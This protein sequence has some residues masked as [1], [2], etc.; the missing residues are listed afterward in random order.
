MHFSFIADI[1]IDNTP[2]IVVVSVD[3]ERKKEERKK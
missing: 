1:E 2:C 3:T